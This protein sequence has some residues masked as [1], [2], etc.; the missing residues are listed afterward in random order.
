MILRLIRAGVDGFRLNFSHGTHEE[1]EEIIKIIRDIEGRRKLFIPIVGD[2][3]GPVVRVGEMEDLPVKR[4]DIVYLINDVKGDIEKKEVPVPNE[5]LYSMI[6]DGD[7]ILI[8]SGRV[9]LQVRNILDVKVKAEVLVDGV[10]KPEKTLAIKGKD[11]PLPTLSDKDVEDVKFGVEKGLDY[12]GLSFVRTARDVK[13]LR[14]ILDS[15]GGEDVKILSKIETKRGVENLKWIV[16]ESDAILV[17][18]GDLAIYY[19]LERIPEIQ[20]DIVRVSRELGKPVM[21]GTQLLDSM[22]ENPIPSRSEVVDVVA[23]IREGVDGLL[24]TGE[25]AIGKYPVESVLWLNRIIREAEKGKIMEVEPKEEELYD[26]FAH[27]IVQ[28]SE[29]LGAKIVAY[30]RKGTTAYRLARY[31]PNS[32]VYAFTPMLK[33]ARQLGIL[34]GVKAYTIDETDPQSA[35]PK[36]IDFLREKQE[37]TL[38]DIVILTAGMTAGATDIIRVEKIGVS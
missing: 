14:E 19:D 38:G 23:A 33:A 11:I 35:F 30:T 31:R 4:G 18:R 34:R 29:S 16:K 22:C 3:Q 8:E 25:T 9:V 17:A 24:L 1:K 21:I 6:E 26:R 27:G 37:I 15:L 36:I 5:K 20:R 32:E 13:G 28:L 2:L 7:V 10:I 12:I